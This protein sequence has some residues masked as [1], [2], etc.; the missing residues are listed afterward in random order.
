MICWLLSFMNR[1]AQETSGYHGLGEVGCG[2]GNKDSETRQKKRRSFAVVFQWMG[3][4]VWVLEAK[5]LISAMFF[6][7]WKS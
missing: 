7:F 3:R 2:M 1:E 5:R 6:C 4:R